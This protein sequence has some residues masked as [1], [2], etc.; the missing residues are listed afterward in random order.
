MSPSFKIKYAINS[1][2]IWLTIPFK[3][4]AS[5]A[6]QPAIFSRAHP[7]VWTRQEI[8]DRLGR[9]FKKRPFGM[10][11]PLS[12]MEGALQFFGRMNGDLEAGLGTLRTLLTCEGLCPAGETKRAQA[13]FQVFLESLETFLDRYC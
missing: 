5:Q 4:I 12:V 13:Y 1:V 2:Y 6:S 9:F 8:A 3:L 11:L 10:T 7:E